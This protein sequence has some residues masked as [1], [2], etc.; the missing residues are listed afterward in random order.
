MPVR[1]EFETSGDD[2]VGVAGGGEVLPPEIDRVLLDGAAIDALVG[3]LAARIEADYAGR[4]PLVVG[5]LTGAV[6]FV[7]DL[8]RRL[9][10]PVELDFVSV[11]SYGRSHV[12]GDGLAWE[13]ALCLPIEGRD[14]IVVEDIIDTGETLLELLAWFGQQSVA[15]VAC[16]ALLSKPARRTVELEA[17]YLGCDIPDEFV[18]GYGLDYAQRFRNLPYI[19]VLKG[20]VYS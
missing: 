20:E 5:V 18:V 15:S 9:S 1:P 13:K 14:V 8:V 3:G 10:C 16:C 7:S 6:F 19:G 17:D 12:R 2:R 4:Q 11:S